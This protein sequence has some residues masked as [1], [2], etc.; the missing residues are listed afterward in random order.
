M[1]NP[2][3]TRDSRSCR[4]GAL[5]WWLRGRW[6]GSSRSSRGFTLIELLVVISIIAVLI[7]ILLPALG[8]SRENARRLKCLTNL[9][10]IGMGLNIY[11]MERSKGLLPRVKPLHDAMGSTGS[12]NKDSDVSLLDLL[13]QYVDAPVPRRSGNARS[14]YIV[15]DPYKCP[16]DLKSNDEKSNFRPVWATA[17]TSYDYV[18]GLYMLFAEMATIRPEKISFAVTKTLEKWH[19]Q[20]KDWSIM[21]DFSD[22]HKVRKTDLPR[23]GLYMSD[24]R[25]DWAKLPTKDEGTLVI[26]D[27][28][29]FGGLGK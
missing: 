1:T 14:E 2:A 5:C 7:S 22:W 9:K 10:G 16:S 24:W 23:N 13:G 3:P 15:T 28:L 25:A 17:G 21:V 27:I 8:A 26:A 20:G 12:N 6:G 19:D 18:P 4:S 11:M 29:K